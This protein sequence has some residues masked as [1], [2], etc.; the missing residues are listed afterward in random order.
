VLNDT[1][2]DN[3]CRDIW[4]AMGDTTDLV[5][6]FNPVA[7]T[8]QLYMIENTTRCD[9]S[10]TAYHECSWCD[11]LF[12]ELGC[13][14]DDPCTIE[15][16]IPER[17]EI[18]IRLALNM[19]MAGSLEE[20]CESQKEIIV[21]YG[22]FHAEDISI[23]SCYKTIALAR[24]CPD[25][26]CAS[27]LEG[28]TDYLGATTTAQ[29]RALIWASRSSAILSFCG[30]TFILYDVLT[31][32]RSRT[33]VY[34]QLLIGM[35]I[36][37]IITALAWV[38]ATTPIDGDALVSMHVEGAIGNEATCKAQAF[39]IQ[40]GFTS[41]FYNVSLAAYYVLV[42]AYDWKEFQ[43]KK[44]RLYMHLIP[45]AVGLGLSFGAITSYHWIE[46]GC[47]LE[48]LPE[49]E[50]WLILV[51]VILPL[52]LSI[53]SITGSMVVVY[54]SVRKRSQ[55]SRKWS[56]GVSKASKLE[57]AV[58]WQCSLYALAFY[59]SW[60]ILFSVYLASIDV[61]GPLYLTL[62][63]AFLAPIQGFTN[64]LV[65]IRPKLMNRSKQPSRPSIFSKL[66]SHAPR[67]SRP[68][69]TEVSETGR[70][71][72]DNVHLMDPSAAMALIEKKS[73]RIFYS[74][75]SRIRI[76]GGS[77]RLDASK[78]A[79]HADGNSSFPDDDAEFS[80]AR[81]VVS[82]EGNEKVQTSTAS[83]VVSGL[84][85]TFAQVEGPRH[86]VETFDD[87]VE[88]MGSAAKG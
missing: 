16:S 75:P 78:G 33:T 63:V 12:H 47:H 9:Q 21:K 86:E 5:D 49:G 66:F 83:H 14:T 17:Y 57:Q 31:D 35:A 56:F 76:S 2:V 34:H 11:P 3:V 53:L 67:A 58:F 73:Y 29:K 37:D 77:S 25:V 82:E 26:V 44:I 36:F 70:S 43:L 87:E 23:D 80:D 62:A 42:I 81:R 54:N 27:P 51:F 68:S 65:Y 28:N 60:P 79:T 4:R 74:K 8:Q 61:H 40:L 13:Y 52:G 6:M 30:A 10:R 71:E 15:A 41:V 19:T 50:I 18:D 48:P 32:R 20:E 22:S 1:E 72:D 85:T 84:R 39:F 64:C 69:A 24:V 88:G 59:I 55:A 46:Y 7:H 45:V 38:F